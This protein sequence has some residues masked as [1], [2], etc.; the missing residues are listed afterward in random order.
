VTGAVA[1][2]ASAGQHTQGASAVAIG[3]QAGQTG[4][5]ANAVAIGHLAGKFH[6]GTGAVAVGFQAGSTGQ[7][8]S[9]VAVGVSAGQTSQRANAVA[10]G[11]SAGQQTQGASAVAIGNLAGSAN[12]G[13]TGAVAIGH[14]SGQDTQGASAVAIG[15]QA[16]QTDQGTNA[17]AIGHN[18]GELHGQTG[19]VAIGHKAGQHQQGDSAVAIGVSAGKTTQTDS[20]V[21]IG[22]NAGSFK[23]GLIG[24][25]RAWN[26]YGPNAFPGD[27]YD[28]FYKDSKGYIWL[29]RGDTI[30]VYDSDNVEQYTF[31]LDPGFFFPTRVNVFYEKGGYMFIGGS[32]SGIGEPLP[33]SSITR[34]SLSNYAI[35][36]L[37]WGDAVAIGVDGAVWDMTD[38]DGDLV[39]VGYFFSIVDI[40]FDN[41]GDCN[42]ICVIVNPYGETGLQVFLGDYY[43]QYGGVDDIVY[44][45]YYDAVNSNTFFGGDFT[46]VDIIDGIVTMN[47]IAYFDEY[48]GMWTPVASNL[49]DNSVYTIADTSYGQL[50]VVGDF[51]AASLGTTNDFNVY[52][53]KFYPSIII[54]D[55]NLAL[56]G[57]GSGDAAYGGGV[58]SVMN[59][60]D[61]YTDNGTFGGWT[62]LGAPLT[63]PSN[64]VTGIDYFNGTWNVISNT[65]EYIRS[66]DIIQ[67]GA[68]VAIGHSAGQYEQGASAV[69]IGFQ[70]GQ[71]GQGPNAIAIGHMAGEFHSGT[72]AV[73][74]GFQ[75]GQHTQS[76][77]A[78]AIGYQAGSTGQG[79]SAV[80]IGA[81]AGQTGQGANAIAIGN[82]AGAT[83]QFGGSIVLNASG[84]ELNAGDT[85]FFVNP[86]RKETSNSAG[87]TGSVWYNPT[88]HEVAFNENSA[89]PTA[90]IYGEYSYW[91]TQSSSWA[92]GSDN[93]HIGANAG[94]TGQQQYAIALGFQAGQTAQGASAVAIGASAGQTSQGANAI[95]IGNLAGATGQFGGSIVL[96]A[97]GVA[98]DAGATGFFVNPIRP[99]PANSNTLHWDSMSN[100]IFY[101]PGVTVTATAPLVESA[102][103]GNESNVSI[104]FT[105][106]K[107]EIPYGIGT[108]KTGALLAPPTDPV[109]VGK[110]LT[111]AGTPSILEWRTPA[112]PVGDIITLHSSVATTPVHKPTD[113]YEQLILVAE[114]IGPSWVLQTSNLPPPFDKAM[115][116]ELRFKSQSGQQF[117]AIEQLG[118][119]T[120]PRR[121]IVIYTEGLSPNYIV[122]TLTYENPNP[123]YAHAFVSCTSNG[124]DPYGVD[125]WAG[126][127]YQNIVIL[128]GRFSTLI[129]FPFSP[130]TPFPCYNIMSIKQNTVTGVWEPHYI[131]A[132]DAGNDF[133]TGIVN[134]ND[135]AD[136]F[137]AV[138][139]I[140]PFSAGALSGLLSAGGGT[141]GLPLPGF[142]VGGT[143]TTIIGNVFGTPS[144]ATQNGYFN[145]LPMLIGANSFSLLGA[146]PQG[147]TNT[148]LNGF[149]IGAT[150]IQAS[151]SGAVAGI[152]FAPNYSYMWVIGNGFE[153]CKDNSSSLYTIPPSTLKG[154]V[155]FYPVAL[156][157]GDSA[158]GQLGAINPSSFGTDFC[159]DIKPSTTLLNHILI[160]GDQLF[161]KDVSV[162]VSGS[163]SYTAVGSPIAPVAVGFP[164]TSGYLNSIASN[165]TITTP[166]GAVTGDFLV[167]NEQ[168]YSAG[169]QYVG[170]FTTAT[171]TVCQPLD[172]I[173]CGPNSVALGTVQPSYGINNLRLGST[174]TIGGDVGEYNYDSD[175]HANINFACDPDVFFKIPAG[176]ASI[177]NATFG[178]SYQSQSY[179]AS[180]DLA[181][182]VQVGEKNINLTYSP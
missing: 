42:N 43:N 161:F 21:A 117:L 124:I 144:Y 101:A 130:T 110:V 89:L 139:S 180:S 112:T 29:A 62:S 95:A 15:F 76:T 134:N 67:T 85:G 147:P 88:T 99:L 178:A 58:T 8:A 78:V 160:T 41:I 167:F 11:A 115:Q 164:V 57:S 10:I 120:P 179:I 165:V 173:P 28:A 6:G 151:A 63:P 34:V 17:V 19:A 155:I 93:I 136:P 106:A 48:I 143:F 156:N 154:F 80:A 39:I 66:N 177:V 100:E 174:L 5:R 70:A 133:W 49:F 125:H 73:A 132:T 44:T 140:T 157:P 22:K 4:Q 146:M 18:A 27:G 40:D 23:Q 59:G 38:V 94:E 75:A 55:T 2:G 137:G 51:T 113:K 79:T 35:S 61:F 96:N 84:V 87:F 64:D 54:S 36:P 126:T 37:V 12:Q 166:T 69:A 127:Y 181:Y 65:H 46:I 50:Y 47:Y 52:V 172:P 14:R 60:T 9:A 109:A 3:F 32:F 163:A 1:I 128:G 16:G 53:D 175:L 171:G 159:W 122:V 33:Q 97:S 150:Q 102:G 31:V 71:T 83:G 30:K 103:V 26:D 182:W 138:Y 169:K 25:P 72:G 13:V 20:A 104:N 170:Y 77:S 129:G 123:A 81:S 68:A 24:L 152:L 149:A 141:T 176:T 90:S 121:E 153:Y 105:Q 158:W 98:L 119:G 86:I 114:E 92:I 118:G 116:P 142:M 148:I 108:L 45:I 135:P 7:G 91:D 56:L 82:L 131:G 145:L 162:P 74:V 111:Y 107:G 168:T